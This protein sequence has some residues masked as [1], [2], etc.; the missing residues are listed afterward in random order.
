MTSG[1]AR[2]VVLDDDLEISEIV[3]EIAE[4]LGFYAEVTN[5]AETFFPAVNRHSPDAIV[6]DLQMPGSDGIQVLRKLA[7]MSVQ[8][9]ILIVSGMD[10][11]TIVAAEQYA[12]SKGLR[13]FG[14][15]QKPFLPEELHEKLALIQSATGPLTV[16]DL[17]HALDRGE[18]AVHYQP[19]VRRFADGTWD[20]ASLEALL[21][22]EHPARGLLTPDAFLAMGEQSGV[23]GPMTDYVIQR[24]IEELKGWQARHLN[25]GLRINIAATLIADIDF[26][27]RLETLLAEQTVDPS[28]LTLEITETAMLDERADTYDIL[29]RLRVKEINLAI[30]DFGIGYS[31]LTQLFRM[32]FNEMKVDKSLVL[33]VP[34]SNE[35]RIMVEALVELAHKLDLT[36][37]AEGVE[38][39]EILDFLNRIGC[40]AAQGFL[41]GRPVAAKD[42]PAAVE[43]W[44][45]RRHD[46]PPIQLQG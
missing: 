29:T 2:L 42:V 33:N 10:E 1:S 18:L 36:V 14:Y 35:A 26:P 15:L 32:P 41:I 12:R 44:N 22:W 27:D 3:G 38:T 19:S 31:S 4:L 16:T 20:I 34:Q 23:I 28:S 21:R 24:G 7:G 6:L 43:R 5:T 37:C 13:V 25:L 46:D 8:A 9:G 17:E 30:D 39:E 11:R 45:R 40:D